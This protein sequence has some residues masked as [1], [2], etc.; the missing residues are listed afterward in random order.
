MIDLVF[1]FTIFMVTLGPIKVVPSFYHYTK[2]M[3]RAEV[4]ML[5]VKGAVVATVISLVIALVVPGIQSSW[6]VTVDDLRIAGGILLFAA[7]FNLLNRDHPPRQRHKTAR[8]AALSP[9]AIPIII[10]PWGAAAILIAVGLVS[11]ESELATVLS[12]LL[13]IMLLN[14]GG[15]LFAHYIMWLTGEA[16][17][18]LLGWVFSVVQAGLSVHV[19]VVGLRNIGFIAPP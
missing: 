6:Q 19:I 13:L 10:T 1:V 8:H 17:W 12:N 15:M 3:G 5:S 2:S 18:K 11:N 7:A 9:I 4:R 14:L 16:F